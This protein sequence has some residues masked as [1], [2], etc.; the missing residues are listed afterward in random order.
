MHP[1]TSKFTTMDSPNFTVQHNAAATLH[2]PITMQPPYYTIVLLHFKVHHTAAAILH[3]YLPPLMELQVKL[4][5][6]P[7]SISKAT[8][9]ERLSHCKKDITSWKASKIADWN[10]KDIRDYHFVVTDCGIE[11]WNFSNNEF[12]S[13]EETET[14]HSFIYIHNAATSALAK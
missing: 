1:S 6:S 9:W 14:Y 2:I 13:V 11:L 3:S 5:S 8:I 12:V 7:Q 10:I 4:H